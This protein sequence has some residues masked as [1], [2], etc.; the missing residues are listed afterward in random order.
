MWELRHG[1]KTNPRLEHLQTLAQFFGVPLRYFFPDDDLGTALYARLNLLN[2]MRDSRIERL[3]VRASGLSPRTLDAI[4]EIVE[5]ARQIEGL[6][7]EEGSSRRRS[8]NV[9]AGIQT[10]MPERTALRCV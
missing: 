6:L 5:Q 7:D 3:A 8:G 1:V 10:V 9:V 4:A 2:A